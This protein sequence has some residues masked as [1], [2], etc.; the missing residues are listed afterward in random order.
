MR[1]GQFLTANG[2]G[3]AG[4]DYSEEEEPRNGLKVRNL[5]WGLG[6]INQ[7]TTDLTDFT[8]LAWVDYSEEGEAQR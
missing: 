1:W 3:F 6:L 7:E 5:G 4:V 2:C 8:N